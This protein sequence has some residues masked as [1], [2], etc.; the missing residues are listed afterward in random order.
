MKEEDR[1]E[2]AIGWDGLDKPK[3]A[4]RRRE[5]KRKLTEFRDK[6]APVSALKAGSARS[7]MKNARSPRQRRELFGDLWRE[8]ELVVL[9]GPSGVGKAVLAMQVAETAARLGEIENGQWTMENAGPEEMDSGQLTVDNAD[10]E[11]LSVVNFPLSSARRVLYF[12]LERTERQRVERYSWSDGTRVRKYEFAEGLEWMDVAD[13]GFMHSKYK[14][15]V[16]R[17]YVDSVF[18]AVRNR[19]PDAV[20]IDNLTYLLRARQRSVDLLTLMKT[21]RRLVNDTGVSVLLLAHSGGRVGR[22]TFLDRKNY[23][24]GFE[25]ADRVL[26]MCQSTMGAGFRYVKT[27]FPEAAVTQDVVA[28]EV[29]R[30]AGVRD[31][32]HA[33]GGEQFLGCEFVGMMPEEAHL[34][35]YVEHAKMVDAAVK[36]AEERF[37]GSRRKLRAAVPSKVMLKGIDVVSAVDERTTP[38]AEAA[39]PPS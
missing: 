22:S 37:G 27:V 35:D 18:E 31:G 5:E 34:R 19:E 39:T 14:G 15:S 24:L 28:F 25:L 30:S 17:F 4:D 29:V 36:R 11:E 6:Y 16:T 12:D 33:A 7:A 3:S 21:L 23:H 38:S 13:F 9:T 26:A 1:W 32:R 20:I 2:S 8:G 10:A